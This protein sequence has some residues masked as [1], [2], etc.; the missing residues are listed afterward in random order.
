MASPAGALPLAAFLVAC[1]GGACTYD[2]EQFDRPGAVISDAG[3]S[4]DAGSDAGDASHAGDASDAGGASDVGDDRN[5]PSDGGDDRSDGGVADAWGVDGADVIIVADGGPTDATSDGDG[6]QGIDC[7][8]LQGTVSQGHCYRLDKTMV[9]W[10]SAASR[11]LLVPNFHLVTVTSAVEQAVVTALA[12]GGSYWIGL[13]EPYGTLK[14]HDE[15]NLEWV[16]APAEH[17]DPATSYRPWA[18]GKGEPTFAGDYVY[19]DTSGQW[20][21]TGVN[22]THW[23]V[24]ERDY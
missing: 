17:Y 15:N 9:T 10:T 21:C 13:S 11:C 3:P 22:A 14:Q 8:L 24:C 6:G 12:S 20:F 2:F 1:L 4:A 5:G 7:A 16:T 18:V 23:S 19:A